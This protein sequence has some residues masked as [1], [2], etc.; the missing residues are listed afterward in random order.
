[1]R[2]EGNLI[3][4][5]QEPDAFDVRFVPARP[6]D[7]IYAESLRVRDPSALERLLRRVGLPQE[8]IIDVL[9]SPYVLHSL[10]IH[11]DPQAARRAGLVETPF[12]R[13]IGRLTRLLR[14]DRPAS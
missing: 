14:H 2:I 6:A 13:L 10:R 11:V 5:W 12:R 7:G 9:R 1:V 3:I 4:R 8:R